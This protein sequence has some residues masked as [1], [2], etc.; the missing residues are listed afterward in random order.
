M[1][2]PT[3]TVVNRLDISV[4]G[5]TNRWNISN[6]NLPKL[7]RQQSEGGG[8][9][10]NNNSFTALASTGVSN[11]SRYQVVWVAWDERIKAFAE[12]VKGTS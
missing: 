11:L 12:V 6:V 5:E 1:V 2:E 10:S 4:T 9:N 8:S 3:E 7:P